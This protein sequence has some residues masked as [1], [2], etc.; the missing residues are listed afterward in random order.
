MKVPLIRIGSSRGIRI[1]KAFLEQCQLQDTV[2]LE[3]RDDHL[4]IRPTIHPR[5]GW[6]DAFRHMHEHGDDALLD[7]ETVSTPEWDTTEWEW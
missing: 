6:D 7:E 1:P 2:E 3:L 4:I 5:S